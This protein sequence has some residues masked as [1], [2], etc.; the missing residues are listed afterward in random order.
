MQK[1]M[2]LFIIIFLGSLLLL[3]NR[4]EKE[5][6][7]EKEPLEMKGLFFS[8]I[9]EEHYFKDKSTKEI[10]KEIE[11]IVREAKDNKFNTIIIQVRSFS[12]ALYNSKIFPKSIDTK[13]D[14][15]KEFISIASKYHIDIYAWVNPYRISNKK[16]SIVLNPAKKWIN[17]DKVKVLEN[18]IYYNPAKKEVRDLI[19]KGVEEIINYQVKGIIFDDYFY[20][21][22]DIDIDD[23]NAYSKKNTTSLKQYHLDNVNLLI[24]EVHEKIK[25]AKRNILFGILYVALFCFV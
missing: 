18:G 11:K 8:Y 7:E 20:P 14:I 17:T 4:E 3:N 22:D 24:K 19:I 16:D 6:R 2:V 13:I 25:K 9:E 10:K 15:L 12:D 23:Y 1:L 21:S 5:T